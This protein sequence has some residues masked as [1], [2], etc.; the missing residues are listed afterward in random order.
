[1]KSIAL[2]ADVSTI[3]LTDEEFYCSRSAKTEYRCG[4][5][6]LPDFG[7]NIPMQNSEVYLYNYYSD[8]WLFLIDK[9]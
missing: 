6:V 9:K 8:I 7:P 2:M 1:V 3:S 5:G 4:V